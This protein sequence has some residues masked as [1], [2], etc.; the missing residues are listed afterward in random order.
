[1]QKE[2]QDPHRVKLLRLLRSVREDAGLTQI[3]VAN[4]LSQPQSFVSKYENGERRLDITEL[5]LVCK[6]LGISLADFVQ[7]LGDE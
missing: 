3:E 5:D 2:P 7:K 1:M 4:R 6:A